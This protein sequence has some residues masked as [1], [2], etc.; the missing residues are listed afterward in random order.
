MC[1]IKE[2]ID[3]EY[4]FEKSIIH[5]SPE[6]EKRL[7]DGGRKVREI[8]HPPIEIS[9]HGDHLNWYFKMR[10]ELDKIEPQ[11]ADD[12]DEEGMP[13]GL[14]TKQHVI[15]YKKTIFVAKQAFKQANA[16]RVGI[17]KRFMDKILRNAFVYLPPKA[18]SNVIMYSNK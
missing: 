13:P 5:I 11:S 10:D 9:W 17:C 16:P 12:D 7:Q 4:E 2:I 15:R 8:L 1:S 18:Y 3:N 14:T 6:D